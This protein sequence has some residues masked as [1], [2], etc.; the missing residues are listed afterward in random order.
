MP[1]SSVHSRRA[2]FD[3]RFA[4]FHAPRHKLHEIASTICDMRGQTKLSDQHK[5]LTSNVDR[6][7]KNYFAPDHN[8]PLL[9]NRICAVLYGHVVAVIIAVC[10]GEHL[11][12][13]QNN[14]RG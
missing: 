1:I 7:H 4:T 9:D 5:F 14:I 13:G 8:V 2:E 3:Q 12:R 10:L 11:G 6:N